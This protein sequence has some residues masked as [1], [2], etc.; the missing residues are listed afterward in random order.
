MNESPRRPVPNEPDLGKNVF[1]PRLIW[2]SW[3]DKKNYWHKC[4]GEISEELT[5]SHTFQSK[6][7]ISK[8]GNIHKH[9]G[10]N[11]PFAWD[12]NGCDLAVPTW[13]F[14]KVIRGQMAGRFEDVTTLWEW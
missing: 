14:I 2:V 11:K 10:L 9:D 7:R 13:D 6:N 8:S 4:P 12:T 1:G 3:N 5:L